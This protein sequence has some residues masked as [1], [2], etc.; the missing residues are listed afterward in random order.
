[1]IKKEII[2]IVFCT[3]ISNQVLIAQND[4]STK[5]FYN[6]H[7]SLGFGFF[8]T[9]SPY[10]SGEERIV[11]LP[12]IYFS[13]TFLLR[14]SLLFEFNIDYQLYPLNL[15]TSDWEKSYPE[16]HFRCDFFIGYGFFNNSIDSYFLPDKLINSTIVGMGRNTGISK[17]YRGHKSNYNKRSGIVTGFGIAYIKN[18]Y[19]P[20]WLKKYTNIKNIQIKDTYP[21]LEIKYFGYS[22]DTKRPIYNDLFLRILAVSNK[23]GFDIGYEYHKFSHIFYSF[24]WN[25]QK[26]GIRYYKAPWSDE[27]YTY[28]IYWRA[29]WSFRF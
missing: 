5:T 11:G 25:G 9:K 16:D 8:I 26:I 27:K 22:L 20:E 17:T 13:S 24:H 28:E 23:I 18:Q 3:I 6:L 15:S 12:S 2:I 21:F 19:E 4:D 7:T 29:F 1:M 10:S 14:K